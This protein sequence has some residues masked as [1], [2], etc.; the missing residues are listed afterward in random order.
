MRVRAV[1]PAAGGA[2]LVKRHE[3]DR[4]TILPKTI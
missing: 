1:L 3:V 4:G 2:L